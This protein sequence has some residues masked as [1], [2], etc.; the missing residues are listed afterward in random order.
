MKSITAK[1]RLICAWMLRQPAL[2]LVL[3]L[4]LT[5]VYLASTVASTR[6]QTVREFKFRQ[7]IDYSQLKWEFSEDRSIFA[8]LCG[9]DLLRSSIYPIY[10]RRSSDGNQFMNSELTS[11]SG[12]SEI[13]LA[14]ICPTNSMISTVSASMK[15]EK[16]KENVYDYVH[17]GCDLVCVYSLPR[18]LLVSQWKIPRDSEQQRVLQIA[19]A[20]LGGL[21]IATP[22]ELAFW[23]ASTG[24]KMW[25]LPTRREIGAFALSRSGKI[26]AVSHSDGAISLWQLPERRQVRLIEGVSTTAQHLALSPHG[27]ILAVAHAD[28][29]VSVWNTVSTKRIGTI[30]SDGVDTEVAI[31]PNGR[32]LL[33]SCSKSFQL[34]RI[35]DMRRFYV[36]K[37]QDAPIHKAV[38]TP[39]N[40]VLLIQSAMLRKPLID[41]DEL[42]WSARELPRRLFSREPESDPFIPAGCAAHA[43]IEC[44]G[45]E[46]RI[47]GM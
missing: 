38:F 44:V 8:V 25:I 14:S 34:W 7:A 42:M 46:M 28:G 29:I 10:L 43:E 3:A 26:L 1:L 11:G 16:I 19:F 17:D 30:K 2:T 6:V 31:S 35:P 9:V 5:A 21:L 18:G 40:R 37:S 12:V 41:V 4:D 22:K 15:R 32:F 20:P 23:Q 47:A 36:Y 39:N 24:K 27:D 13:Y 33:I 45:R